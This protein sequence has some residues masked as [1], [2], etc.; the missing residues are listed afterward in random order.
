MLNC[1]YTIFKEFWFD[2][3]IFN[4]LNKKQTIQI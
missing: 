4:L 3:N 2:S 1:T